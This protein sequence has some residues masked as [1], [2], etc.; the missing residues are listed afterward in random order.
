MNSLPSLAEK[1]LF[2]SLLILALTVAYQSHIIRNS[3]LSK[4]DYSQFQCP[5][6]NTDL[7]STHINTTTGE[8]V[9]T[10]RIKISRPLK[11]K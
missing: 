9:C 2:I 6:S 3:K 11:G 4:L 8:V 1:L 10:Y 7:Q 5:S